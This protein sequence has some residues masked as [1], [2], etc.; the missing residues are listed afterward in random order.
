MNSTGTKP[1]LSSSRIQAGDCDFIGLNNDNDCPFLGSRFAGVLCSEYDT[2]FLYITLLHT[3]TGSSGSQ[4]SG[5]VRLLVSNDLGKNQGVVE[6]LF[7][8]Q[9]GVLCSPVNNRIEVAGSICEGQGYE[10][11]DASLLSIST[12]L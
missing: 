8:D 12:L 2:E 1:L 6:I 3:I 7:N 9:W 4:D 11:S 5:D 10:R